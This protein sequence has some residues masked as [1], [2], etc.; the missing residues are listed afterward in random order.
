[1][2]GCV[3]QA[4]SAEEIGD[5]VAGEKVFK[6]CAK[7]HQVGPDAVNRVGPV[8]NDVFG[9]QAGTVEDFTRYSKGIVRMGVDGLHWD[10]EHLD[11]Y[12]ENPK[13]LVSGTRMSFRGLKDPQERADVIAYLR[14]FSASPQNIPEAAPTALPHEVALSPEVL[15]IV[16]DPEYGEYLS[17]ECNTCHQADGEDEGIPSITGWPDEDFV[18]AMHAYKVKARPH[19]VMQM[20]AGRLTDEE[21][22]ALAAYYAG[23]GAE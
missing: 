12:L 6:E 14:T 15:A 7:C 9:R 20:M 11:T 1:M 18:V 13:S 16:G 22:A 2:A 8:L 4:A 3:T 19:P 21:I 10:I 5:P 17:A 23:L